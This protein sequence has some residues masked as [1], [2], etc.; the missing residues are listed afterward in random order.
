MYIYI[1]YAKG[2]QNLKMSSKM[3]V[4][5]NSMIKIISCF[6]VILVLMLVACYGNKLQETEGVKEIRLHF[7][8]EEVLTASDFVESRRVVLLEDTDET[9]IGTISKVD[10]VDSLLI[11]TDKNTRSV[12]TY[13][14]N[15]QLVGKIKFH[16]RGPGEYQNI[17]LSWINH[18][19]KEVAI[20]D[21]NQLKILLY[22]LHG[23]FV[24]EYRA[25]SYIQGLALHGDCGY[26][27]R[28]MDGFLDDA[29]KP[30]NFHLI[31]ASSD[32]LKMELHREFWLCG[33]SHLPYEPFARSN[34]NI[35]LITPGEQNIYELSGLDMRL[36]YHVEVGP[37]P[38][39]VNDNY[40]NI[41]TFEDHKQFRIQNRGKIEY[42]RFFGGDRYLLFKISL[43]IDEVRGTGSVF[44]YDTIENRVVESGSSIFNDLGP[45]DMN[46]H[47]KFFNDSLWISVAYQYEYPPSILDT[48][49]HREGI[50]FS[51][52][53]NPMLVISKLKFDE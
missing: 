50:D 22:T 6:S 12:L 41:K 7:D 49:G 17:T 46:N 35:L 28:S 29:K 43:S 3:F 48:I 44:I 20:Y 31:M 5:N 39:W 26:Y 19:T 25:P 18:D 4:T 36:K 37:N 30:S 2:K 15:G 40:R 1:L 13:D 53:I 24:K 21:D 10:V 45:Y 16:G 52:S 42:V 34:G 38:M 14:F 11:I 8:K 33:S 9:I 23:K 51:K 47:F 27:Y 32:S